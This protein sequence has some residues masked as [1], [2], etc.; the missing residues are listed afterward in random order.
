MS[1]CRNVSALFLAV[2]T[3][4]QAQAARQSL[5]SVLR[6]ERASTASRS[7]TEVQPDVTAVLAGS[8]A[9]IDE[10]KT[11]M[12]RLASDL[13]DAISANFAKDEDTIRVLLVVAMAKNNDAKDIE[14]QLSS[15]VLSNLIGNQ[16]LIEA[17]MNIAVDNGVGIDTMKPALVT[18]LA[19]RKG[20][21]D[22]LDIVLGEDRDLQAVKEFYAKLLT[23]RL[24]ANGDVVDGILTLAV[25]NKA[26]GDSIRSALYVAVFKDSGLNNNQHAEGESILNIVMGKDWAANEAAGFELRSCAFL[27][28]K[29]TNAKNSIVD[30]V[31][32]LS[33]DSLASTKL[34]EDL[35]KILSFVVKSMSNH[36][37]YP[38]TE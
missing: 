14:E 2:L 20:V 5:N 37:A 36:L 30:T 12:D 19:K 28:S 34:N 23:I 8:K 11:H 33:S 21:D 3:I 15:F 27:G 13:R 22:L 9:S 6:I 10:A 26:D 29:L 17:V 31:S 7:P 35:Q 16:K 25:R 18:V 24:V 4:A 38:E 32:A 1:T